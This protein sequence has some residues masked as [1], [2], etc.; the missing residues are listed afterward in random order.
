MKKNINESWFKKLLFKIKMVSQFS[1]I[2][3]KFIYNL[4]NELSNNDHYLKVYFYKN[5]SYICKFLYGDDFDKF[6]ILYEKD[7]DSFFNNVL[8][9]KILHLLKD[10][11]NV[12]SENDLNTLKFL[13]KEFKYCSN[14]PDIQVLHDTLRVTNDENYQ[15][16]VE[17]NVINRE[18][19]DAI[20]PFI[21]EIGK[22]EYDDITKI[23]WV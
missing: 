20:M 10:N 18:V 16:L 2:R 6:K 22:A 17:N 12:I 3:K 11:Y 4:N 8:I 19:K 15:K 21:K 23:D 14:I 9:Y 1:D 13:S 7:F 5:I